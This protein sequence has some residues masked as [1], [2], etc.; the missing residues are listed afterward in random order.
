MPWDGSQLLQQHHEAELSPTPSTLAQ[1]CRNQTD[2]GASCYV[3]FLPLWLFF[4]RFSPRFT[5]CGQVRAGRLFIC[6]KIILCIVSQWAV[7]AHDLVKVGVSNY[8][9]AGEA[10]TGAL[11]ALN[12]ELNG[13]LSDHFGSDSATGYSP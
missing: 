10:L 4:S 12:P 2:G 1:A 5:S 8:L 11:G 6:F 9:A 7:G 13:D 3:R